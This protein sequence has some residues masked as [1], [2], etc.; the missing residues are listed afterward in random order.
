MRHTVKTIFQYV[1][2][3]TLGLLVLGVSFT[4]WGNKNG[5]EFDAVLT[6]SMEPTF[7]VGGLVVVCP[8]DGQ[9]VKLG[10]AISFKIPGIDTPICHRIIG[11]EYFAGEKYLRTKGDANENPDTRL[12]PLSS[13][14]GK[15]IFYLPYVGRL[16]EVNRW[17]SDQIVLFGKH[18]P[19]AIILV[20]VAGLVFIFLILKDTVESI[21][22]PERCRQREV[23][24]K[25]NERLIKRRK[26][27]RI[28]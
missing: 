11:V 9:T 14:K 13:V 3:V 8:A 19:A 25:Q 28:R 24:K 15:A 12:V 27:F 20:L 23:R 16:I 18:L 26:I 6:G 1:S 21:V 7:K 2:W 4:N 22:F 10:D 17:G 5:W